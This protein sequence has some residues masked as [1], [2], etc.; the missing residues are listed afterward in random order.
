MSA[1][2]QRKDSVLTKCSLLV[3]GSEP[4][5]K[6]QWLQLRLDT[7]EEYFHT[8]EERVWCRIAEMNFEFAQT[9]SDMCI[10]L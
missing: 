3:S 4:H 9:V 1:N 8:L 10:Y 7:I 6:E 5:E 2:T